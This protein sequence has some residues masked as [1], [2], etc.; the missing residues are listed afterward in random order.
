[1]R[2]AESSKLDRPIVV[3]VGFAVVLM[4]FMDTGIDRCSVASQ[5]RGFNT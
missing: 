5:L 1:V 2:Q 3:T 4:L